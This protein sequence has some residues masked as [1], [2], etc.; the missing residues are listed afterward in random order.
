M[1]YY[2]SLKAYNLKLKAMKEGE[3]W[4]LHSDD[5]DVLEINVCLL[6]CCLLSLTEVE[7]VQL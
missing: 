5:N 2:N 6:F 3:V 1:I 7:V 4:P